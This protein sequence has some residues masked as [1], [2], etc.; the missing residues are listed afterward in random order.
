MAKFPGPEY[1]D[2]VQ[3]KGT[4]DKEALNGNSGNWVS[5]NKYSTTAITIQLIKG[6]VV[7]QENKYDA[8]GNLNNPDA[9]VIDFTLAGAGGNDVAV[10]WASTMENS[11]TIF[12]V[13][14]KLSADTNYD[15]AV[16]ILFPLGVGSYYN[17]LDSVPSAGNYSY[18]LRAIFDNGTD[19]VLAEATRNIA[20]VPVPDASVSGFTLTPNSGAV[21]ASWTTTTEVSVTRFDLDR[22]LATDPNYDFSVQICFPSGVRSSYSITDYPPNSGTYNYKLRAVFDN[23]TDKTLGEGSVTV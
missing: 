14:R 6:G 10:S 20:S 1:P 4:T 7:V 16:Q 15:Q 21:D 18:R 5:K 17:V 3:V 8:N 19:K 2:F 23:G 9:A 12:A 22:K 11:V 13:D